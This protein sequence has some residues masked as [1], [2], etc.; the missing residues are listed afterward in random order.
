MK[1]QGA[2]ANGVLE[3]PSCG[4]LAQWYAPVH[5]ASACDMDH[6]LGCL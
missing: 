1:N 5:Q 6:V 2:M 4:R 3:W